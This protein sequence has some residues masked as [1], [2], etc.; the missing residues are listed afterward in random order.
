MLNFALDSLDE[1]E[2]R[3]PDRVLLMSPAIELT[4]VA[5]LANI[6]DVLSIVPIPVLE[7]VRWQEI[8][9]KYDPYK[10]NSFPVNAA[11][12]VNQ[13]TKK[14]QA[15][16]QSAEDGGRLA[17]LPPVVTWQSVVDSTV[18]SGGT[19]DRLYARLQGGRHR[20]VIFDVNR[21]LGYA[22]M[23]RPAARQLIDRAIA[24]H[25]GYTLEVVSNVSAAPFVE[26]LD[27]AWPNDGVSLGHVSLPFP[28][29]DP[30]YGFLPGSGR[31]GVPSLGSRLLRGESGALTISLGSLT[32]LRSNPFWGLIDA[33]VGDLVAADSA[34]A[35]Q[36]GEPVGLRVDE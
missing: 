21:F 34:G 1:K 24:T 14:L 7:K 26:P 27:L 23:Q 30:L 16:L 11:R 19:V 12:Q 8:L 35:A 15:A 10:F 36:N 28:P 22:S 29:D 17:Q 6:I 4:R 3:R 32:R 31:N 33:Q 25:P 13:A 18:G 2:L 20:L 9:P 5:A